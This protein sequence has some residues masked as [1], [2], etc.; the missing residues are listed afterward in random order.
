[1]LWFTNSA[2]NQFF[3]LNSLLHVETVTPTPHKTCCVE[4][5]TLK[6]WSTDS[7]SIWHTGHNVLTTK[8]QTLRLCKVGR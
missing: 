7:S 2:A 6:R 5:H 1:M 8:L 4:V 3:Q